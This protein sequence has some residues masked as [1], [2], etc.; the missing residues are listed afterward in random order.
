[1]LAISRV[2]NVDRNI[3]IWKLKD[4]T[5]ISHSCSLDAAVPCTDAVWVFPV[6]AVCGDG[7]VWH[8]GVSLL[9]E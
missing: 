7:G 8:H 2:K 9:R 1:M 6:S 3:L 4:E 5:G